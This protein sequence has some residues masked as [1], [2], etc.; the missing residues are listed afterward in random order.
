[1]DIHLTTNMGARDIT[2]KRDITQGIKTGARRDPSEH[3]VPNRYR[4]TELNRL[5]S[6]HQEQSIRLPPQDRDFH[7][8]S[9]EPFE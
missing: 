1:M 5:P 6:V 7:D 4:C 3:P 8:H 2:I 9:I